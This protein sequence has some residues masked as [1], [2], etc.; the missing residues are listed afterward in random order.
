MELVTAQ[1]V[2]I[3]APSFLCE[4]LR[5]QPHLFNVINLLGIITL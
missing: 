5:T 3:V 4:R 1:T 2:T